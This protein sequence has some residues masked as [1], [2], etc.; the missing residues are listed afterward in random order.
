MKI[1]QI[2]NCHY[3]RG[4]ADVVYL[5]TGALLNS[6]G[7]Q[8][9][10]FSTI[11]SRNEKT[12]FDKYF[13][14]NVDYLNNSLLKKLISITRFFY[15]FKAKK[16]INRL[17]NEHMPDIAHV[18]LYKGGLTS[19]VFKIL[20][21]H[22]IPIVLSQHDYGLIDPHNLL[23]DGKL[24]INESTINGSPFN[25][26]LLKSNRNSY[27]LSLVSTFEYLFNKFFF[28]FDIY[29][30]T[31]ICVSKFAMSK[32]RLSKKFNFNLV[33]LYNF[34]PSLENTI[35]VNIPGEYVLYFG[36]L[37]K[38]KGL[39]TL[40]QAWNKSETNLNLKIAG[41]GE[42]FDS[43]NSIKSDKIEL[44][45]FKQGKALTDLM[46]NS[47]FI[48]VPSE[49][50]ENNPLTIIES[51]SYGKPVIASNIG[52]IPEIVINDKTGY[53]FK[54]KSIDSLVSVI[55]KIEQIS[56]NDYKRLSINAR[57]FSNENFN[58]N[59]HYDKLINIYEKTIK[60]YK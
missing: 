39:N 54:M 51:Y 23:L 2:N 28:P 60:S 24:N 55:K 53:L 50:Y 35:P 47:S 21:K 19:S 11:N 12:S 56:L 20:K 5:N 45:G 17:I 44:L 13:I 4:G 52:G 41:D 16:N 59:I 22:K 27:L 34:F 40:I 15:S 25:T 42:L 3:R 38:E 32:H 57:E 49:W 30:N 46:I 37:S 6:K 8:V 26:F 9:F 10:Y 29:F 43:I 18:H 7:N 31:I 48:V 58:P 33:H 1:L 36:R 14:K